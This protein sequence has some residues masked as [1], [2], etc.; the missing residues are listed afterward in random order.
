M[1]E[2]T[3]IVATLELVSRAESAVGVA[4]CAVTLIRRVL[5]ILVTITHKLVVHTVTTQ[6]LELSF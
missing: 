5:A 1:Q 2:L 3:Y 6:A 4:G